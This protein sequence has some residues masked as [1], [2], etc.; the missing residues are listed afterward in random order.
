MKMMNKTSLA[1]AMAACLGIAS[2]HALAVIKLVPDGSVGDPAADPNDADLGGPVL[3]AAE[4]SGE[5]TLYITTINNTQANVWDGD[6]SVHLTKMPTNYTVTATKTLFARISL[7]GGAKFASKPVLVCANTDFSA[8][9]ANIGTFAG[10]GDYSAGWV[11]DGVKVIA[12]ASI[13]AEVVQ[14]A[15]AILLEPSQ[16]GDGKTTATFTFMSGTTTNASGCIVTFIHK[17]AND[18]ST[19]ASPTTVNRVTAFS[20]GTRQDIGLNVEV[21]YV[22]GGLVTTAVFSG[23]IIKFV[24]ALKANY[25]TSG[26]VTIDVKQA[27]KKFAAGNNGAVTVTQAVLGGISVSASE[28]GETI[29]LASY[30]LAESNAAA[31]MATGTITVSGPLL[32]GVKSVAIY[33]DETCDGTNLGSQIPATSTSGSS[34]ATDSLTILGIKIGDIIDTDGGVSVCADVGG[35]TTLNNGQITATLLGGGVA[36]FVPDFEGGDLVKVDINGVRLRVL[37]IP[38]A[39]DADQAYIRFY[40]GSSQDAVV[41]ATLYGMDGKRIGGDNVTLFSPLKGNDVEVLSAATLAQKIGEGTPVTW[42]GRAWLLV[43]AEADPTAFR[44]Q[45][46][47]R[48][49]TNTLINLSTDAQD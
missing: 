20:I 8:A 42:T 46:L 34:G 35:N 40:N 14:A 30:P 5:A 32:A 28:L 39:T 33:D 27:S 13:A 24:T 23:T 1:L 43:Q 49:P 15:S 18:V 26:A 19:G 31:V 12:T 38:P 47:V 10:A 9:A 25:T 45:A 6:L 21:G 3:L 16:G 29:R 2:P 7:T 22:Q 44:V 36:N 41:R 11:A 4:Q 37:N 17:V 48:S